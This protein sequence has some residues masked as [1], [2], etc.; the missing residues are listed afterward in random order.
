MKIKRFYLNSQKEIIVKI[1]K[2][3]LMLF[4]IEIVGEK[5]DGFDYMALSIENN[6]FIDKDIRL[7]TKI[8]LQG[9]NAEWEIFTWSDAALLTEREG[10][11]IHRL[12]KLNLYRLFRKY[13]SFA[14]APWGI[15]YGVRPTKIVH[16]YINEKMHSDAIV[17]RLK[18]DY[19]VS[20]EK[21]ALITKLAFK[22][23]PFLA[24]SHNKMVSV[25]IG[26]PF[27]LSRC[28][29]CSF[30]AYVLPK[31]NVLLQFLLVLKKDLL[32]AKDAMERH[33]LI[34]QN[35]YIGGGTPT[36]LPEKYF[37]E[38]LDLVYNTFYGTSVV[39]FTVEAGRPDS[40]TEGKIASMVVHKVSRVSANPQTMQARTLQRIGRNHTPEAV[41]E[42][43]HTLRDAGIPHINMDLIIGLP[44]ENEADITDTM[45]KVIVLKPDDITLHALALKKGS[46]LKLHLDDVELPND[47]M[48][49]NMFAI[50]L[51]YVKN[52]GLE[53]YYLYR[54]GYM[55]GQLENIGCS[56][57]GAEGMYN[58]QIMEENQT[59][60]G[61][62]GAATT[63]VVHPVT[64]RL[65]TSFNAKDLTTY[66]NSVDKYIERRSNLIDEAYS[67]L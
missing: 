18:H 23:R 3:V 64:K 13:F 32:A 44:G 20:D 34:V 39:E 51:Q 25:Y 14:A 21:A 36:S 48:A 29:Y 8:S 15:L 17:A 45:K 5:T 47:Q 9:K 10:A 1:V 24:T 54:Q 60:I 57:P 4:K 19:E 22:Q 12:I 67:V 37:D 63:K 42:M 55:S 2:E 59:I 49:Q 66:L 38:L 31:E 40:I 56:V 58:I 62:G 46:R 43:F 30:P 6:V 11:A 61:I 33:G 50:A 65:Q 35:I 26:I 16:R 28:L 52:A 53:P 41:I 27:C 7:D